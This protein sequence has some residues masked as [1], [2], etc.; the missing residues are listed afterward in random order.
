MLSYKG[1]EMKPLDLS[2][3][4]AILD[5]F[6]ADGVEAVAISFLHSYANPS[7]EQTALAE[8]RR[9]WPQVAVVASHQITREWREY[10]RT[11]T[12]VLSA[13]VQPTAER[14]LSRLAA[15]LK[16][17][18]FAKSPY[19]MQSNCGVDSLEAVSQDPDHHGGVGAGFRLLGRGRARQ[20]DRRAQRARPRHRRYHGEML[21]DRERPG[22]DHDRLLD[23]A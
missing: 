18:G 22:E 3:L 1:E 10:E 12:A 4:P 11:N 20:A 5:D 17:R 6:R 14:Y 23:R 2:G 7:H 8:V 13:Y 9:L 16:S 15:G 21:A 19:I